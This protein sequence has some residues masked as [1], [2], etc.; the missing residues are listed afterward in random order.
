MQKFIQK[1]ILLE[2]MIHGNKYKILMLDGKIVSVLLCIAPNITG[3]GTTTIKELIEEKNRIRKNNLFTSDKL[4]KLDY[5]LKK[6]LQ[7]LN[8]SIDTIFRKK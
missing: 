5:K 3:N 2:E 6:N 1:K 7:S 4:I 8:L